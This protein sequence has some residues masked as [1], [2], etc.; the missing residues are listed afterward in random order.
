MDVP[1]LRK[2]G[3]QTTHRRFA[4]QWHLGTVPILHAQNTVRNRVKELSKV[5][6]HLEK[7]SSTNVELKAV[8]AAFDAIRYGKS[9]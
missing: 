3:G 2:Q 5:M 9:F 4:L 6:H 8:A 7:T 1:G